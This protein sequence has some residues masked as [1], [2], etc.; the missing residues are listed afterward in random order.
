MKPLQSIIR[1]L[2]LGGLFAG[3]AAAQDLAK[4]ADLPHAIQILDNSPHKNQLPCS[5]EFSENLRLDLLFRYTAGFS[6]ECR[7]GEQIPPGTELNVLLRITP[8]LGKP[9][10]MTERFDVPPAQQQ[11]SAGMLAAPSQLKATTSGGF[12]AGPGEYSVEVLLTDPQGHSCRKQK[13]MKP[14]ADRGARKVPFAMQPGAV[15]PLMSTRWNGAL[16]G[17]GPR[18]TIFVNAYGPNGRAY[19]HALDRT[20]LLQSL[21]TLLT[22]LPCRSVKLIAFDLEDQRAIFSQ[23][24]FDARGFIA[25]ERLLKRVD[26][27]TISYKALQNGSWSKFLADQVRSELVS[28]QPA[29]DIVFLGAWGSHVWEKLPQET[30]HKI[31]IGNTHVFY[32]ELFPYADSTPD[33]I[34]QLTRDL[35]GTVFAIHSPDDFAQAIKKTSAMAAAPSNATR[36]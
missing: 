4:E 6:I 20:A 34:E 17:K 3:A 32:F 2:M 25:L 29:D 5:I 10:V 11:D 14:L 16:A 23:E 9:V 1:L 27:S 18:L 13:D 21:Y 24:R 33:G 8:R 31:E 19:L 28:R 30:V 7:L 15:A 12:V 35:H 22:Q 26:F 36:P